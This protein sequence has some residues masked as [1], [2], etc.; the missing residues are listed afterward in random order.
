MLLDHLHGP[1][2]SS[3]PAGRGA[4]P[5]EQCTLSA[6]I[7][8]AG[9]GVGMSPGYRQII[10]LDRLSDGISRNNW[11]RG[12]RANWW[13]SSG[14]MGRHSWC[15][16]RAFPSALS[17]ALPGREASDTQAL[18]RAFRFLSAELWQS[19]HASI[20]FDGWWPMVAGVETLGGRAIRHL[21]SMDGFRSLTTSRG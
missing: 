1:R 20:A 3:V 2:P 17:E 5:M 11:F 15:R 21:R 8:G 9:G 16:Q 7:S 12:P 6:F 10:I 18:R 13:I 19:S 14:R 4:G